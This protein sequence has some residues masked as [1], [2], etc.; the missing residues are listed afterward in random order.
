M[1]LN[2]NTWLIL[3]AIL[4]SGAAIKIVLISQGWQHRLTD[5]QRKLSIAKAGMENART[6]Q[7]MVF[8]TIPVGNGHADDLRLELAQGGVAL[9][10]WAIACHLIVSTLTI[11]SAAQGDIRLAAVEKSLPMT[12]E[13]IKRIGFLL[14]INFN[15]LT[16]LSDFIL[17]IPDTGGYLSN[18]KIKNNEAALTINF[19]GV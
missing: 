9:Y 10:Q 16:D 4:L 5:A 13:T 12:N 19:I 17:K 11:N 15:S 14:K 8:A 18:I 1:K 2:K 6:I 3:A 7:K